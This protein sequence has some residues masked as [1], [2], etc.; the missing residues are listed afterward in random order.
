L[1]GFKLLV[2]DG[3]GVWFTGEEHRAVLGDG[4]VILMKTRHHH[5]GQGLSFLRAVGIR[6][7][8]AT[9]EGEPLTSVVGKLN[10]LPSVRSGEWAPIAA[11]TG[12]NAKGAKV[13]AVERWLEQEGLSWSDVAYIGDDRSDYDC[14]LRAGL[15]VTPGNGQRLIRRIAHVILNKNGGAGAIREFAE[16]VLDAREI[17][18]ATLPMA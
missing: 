16:M 6:V 2:L 7:L 5:D 4:Q 13:D 10:A 9:A 11:L 1:A 3:D 17:D 14:M 18:E 8:F 15:S 12:L